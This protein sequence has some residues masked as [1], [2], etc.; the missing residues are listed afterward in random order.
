MQVYV[1]LYAK[2]KGEKSVK[3]LVAKKRTYGY[4]FEGRTVSPSPKRL[5]NNAGVPVFPGGRAHQIIDNAVIATGLREFEEETGVS[6]DN[7][8][9]RKRAETWE[10]VSRDK[11][12]SRAF[13][14]CQFPGPDILG[15][16]EKTINEC[17]T[18]GRTVAAKVEKGEIPAGTS[19]DKIADGCPKCNELDT[20]EIW[21]S[22][23]NSEGI[24]NWLYMSD[25]EWFH[26]ALKHKFGSLIPDA[27]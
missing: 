18:V 8:N 9:V 27:S 5:L 15:M 22:E 10:Y 16:L 6:I 25:T 20:V 26:A 24:K 2:E 4:F 21:D 3:L 17:L 19:V 14:I 11:K 12:N 1:I 13:V 23:T 7:A